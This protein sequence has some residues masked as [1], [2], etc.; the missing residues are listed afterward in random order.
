[1][2]AEPLLS[3]KSSYGT[4]RKEETPDLDDQLRVTLHISEIQYYF[5]KKGICQFD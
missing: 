3:G 2:S 1:M 4:Y 5:S